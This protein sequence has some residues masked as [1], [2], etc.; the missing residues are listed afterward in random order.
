MPS[1]AKTMLRYFYIYGVAGLLLVL[2]TC[3]AIYA[4]GQPILPLRDYAIM[5]GV[6]QI[7][8]ALGL[9]RGELEYDR[10]KRR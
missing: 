10:A 6:M 3:G 4:M 2:A 5:A 7:F 9:M 8:C 1:Y